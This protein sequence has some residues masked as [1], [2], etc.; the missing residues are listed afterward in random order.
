M[1]VLSPQRSP[2]RRG[3]QSE[4]KPQ[5]TVTVNAFGQAREGY[6]PN[7]NVRTYT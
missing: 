2:T 6:G 1:S 4:H 7:G 5:D 3:P